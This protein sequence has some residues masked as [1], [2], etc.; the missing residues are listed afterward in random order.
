MKCADLNEYLSFAMNAIALMQ[1]K[2]QLA[3]VTNDLIDQLEA[4]NV[5]FAEIRFA[6][7][8]HIKNG[9]KPNEVVETVLNEVAHRSDSGKIKL[10]VILCTLRSFPVDLSLAT[11]ELIASYRDLGIVGFDIAGDESG[12]ALQDHLPAFLKAKSFGIPI[13]AHSGEA[14]GAQSVEETIRLL[15]PNRIGHGTRSVEDDLVLN[16]IINKKIHL[17]VC[18]GSNVQTNVIDLLSDHPVTTFKQ[19]GVSFSINTDGRT[20]CDTTLSKEWEALSHTF[21]WGLQEWYEAS[22][23]A[24]DH[25]FTDEQTKTLLRQKIDL[26]CATFN[27]DNGNE[28]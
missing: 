18:P 10:G 4:D 17:E 22:L 20:I 12:Y 7:F 16:E 19:K 8:L 9:L 5:I 24:I 27:F 13:T 21:G 14:L 3:I 28:A 2:E 11:V 1:T 6:P 15:N 23:H 26:A 25:A